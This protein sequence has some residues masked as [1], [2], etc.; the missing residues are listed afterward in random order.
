[1]GVTE[2]TVMG[3]DHHS[4]V[5]EEVAPLL[6]IEQG[7]V[8]ECVHDPSICSNTLRFPSVPS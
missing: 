6:A 1:M 7:V 2:R 4:S 3:L 8:L 5:L